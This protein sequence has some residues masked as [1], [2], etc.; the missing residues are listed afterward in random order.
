MATKNEAGK[1]APIVAGDQDND[2]QDVWKASVAGIKKTK[3]N[4][5][6][7][8]SGSGD[9]DNDK[10]KDRSSNGLRPQLDDIV[11]PIKQELY[12]DKDG[13]Y[14]VAVTIRMYNSSKDPVE[15]FLVD[16]SLTQTDGGRA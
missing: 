1:L 5:F 11:R 16:L 7:F 4:G 13:K 8:S 14:K 3:I 9:F 6:G 15:K 10:D 2:L 12:L